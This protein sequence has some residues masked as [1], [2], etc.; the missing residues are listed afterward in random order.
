MVIGDYHVD[1]ACGGSGHAINAGD[2]IVNGHNDVGVLFT[3]SQLDNLRCQSIPVLEAVGHDVVDCRTQTAQAAQADCTGG[4]AIAVIV[5][6]DDH[7]FAGSNG[8]GQ[9]DRRGIDVQQAGRRNQ[10]PEFTR[11]IFQ[12]KQAACRIDTRQYRMDA[13]VDQSVGVTQVIG[14]RGD[15]NHGDILTPV[16][17]VSV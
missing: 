7:F 16:W 15:L 12:V 10:R 3:D 11:Q 6:D 5:G 17:L 4:G 9:I 2:A 13:V 1:A 8:I 14:T